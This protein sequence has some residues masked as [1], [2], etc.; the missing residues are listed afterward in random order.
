[1][2]YEQLLEWKNVCTIEKCENATADELAT[3]GTI[4]FDIELKKT[5]GYLRNPD[6]DHNNSPLSTANER[7]A[8]CWTM[9]E[10]KLIASSHSSGKAYKDWLMD[11]AVEKASSPK[12]FSNIVFRGLSRLTQM[13]VRNYS[14]GLLAQMKKDQL[15]GV[16]SLDSTDEEGRSLIDR[17]SRQA[18]QW[19]MVP[20]GEYSV[21]C[22]PGEMDMKRNHSFTNVLCAWNARNM[23]NS[24]LTQS[25]IVDQL[26]SSEQDQVRSMMRGALTGAPLPESLKERC[27]PPIHKPGDPRIDYQHQ[28]IEWLD[29]IQDGEEWAQNDENLDDWSLQLPET[30]ELFPARAAGDDQV[31]VL[32]GFVWQGGLDTFSQWCRK[33]EK[34]EEPVVTKL[35]AITRESAETL[36]HAIAPFMAVEEI[37]HTGSDVTAHPLADCPF[38]LFSRNSRRLMAKGE[39]IDDGQT[40]VVDHFGFL[41]EIPK[42]S[43]WFFVI[44]SEE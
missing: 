2:E 34:Q 9:L 37:S 21:P 19:L 10:Q 8:I 44:C 39:V 29:R 24:T 41:L 27:G 20:F 30:I 14:A 38:L 18:D 40:A 3:T 31:T 6:R 32:S 35:S 36:F 12:H 23:E 5:A 26:N 33:K 17:Y 43:E 25:W 7:S 13:V 42:L 16:V 28:E 1:M 11:Y 15:A 22:I 4:L